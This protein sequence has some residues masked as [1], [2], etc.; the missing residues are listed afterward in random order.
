MILLQ[1][2]DQLDRH[3]I[4]F[5]AGGA[6][7]HP[8]PDRLIGRPALEDGR[9]HV[10]RQPDEGVRIAE[11]AR[12]V[13][14]Q[15][16]VEAARLAGVALE[17]LDVVADVADPVQR[18]P[19]E[20]PP[21]DG[22]Q[23]VVPEVDAA[24]RLEHVV[25]PLQVVGRHIVIVGEGRRRHVAAHAELR[26]L[27]A[28]RRRRQ[29]QIDHPG[30]DRGA[31]HA[32]VLRRLRRLR[33][34]EAAGALHV[35]QPD[36]A[37]AG[38]ARQDHG[39]APLLHRLGKGHEEGV[40]RRMAGPIRRP[41]REM[42]LG[43]AH[44]HLHVR[45]DHVDV[46]GLDP[47]AFLGLHHGQRGLDGEQRHQRALVVGR[48]VLDEDDG[49]VLRLAAGAQ[50][51]GERLEA[52]GRGADADD[53]ERA[54]HPS[55]R[56]HSGR[57]RS[58]TRCRGLGRPARAA[59]L[60]GAARRRGLLLLRLLRHG[61]R[62]G[63]HA[64]L[65]RSGLPADRRG[66]CDAIALAEGH[67]RMCSPAGGRCGSGVSRRGMALTPALPARGRTAR[68]RRRSRLEGATACTCVSRSAASGMLG[69][70]ASSGS[71]TMAIPPRRTIA[72]N[73]RAPSSSAPE[74][75]TP[76]TPGPRDRAAVRNRGSTAGRNR[77][78][79]GPR[80]TRSPL[81]PMSTCRSAGA[82]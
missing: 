37:V 36:G 71:W 48:E 44:R 52:A 30:V 24:D 3:R 10:R 50:D 79:R 51:L 56:D 4:G 47:H 23:L 59:G 69:T 78:S 33:E 39:D 80:T 22:R 40:D 57:L 60:H 65:P 34:R 8:D 62:G 5:L 35:G 27:G 58:A 32:V 76:M 1:E 7:R 15:I 2:L 20:Q 61:C 55:R 38:G 26:Q 66:S 63:R 21:L 18:H 16:L 46:P 29:H 49:D 81:L 12:H 6:P 72:L 25:D 14:Q 68:S 75:M 43:A 11:E 64:S 17:Q 41:R 28:D 74:R 73:P 77:F 54:A 31:R 45:R 53:R 42:Q 9:E 19:P 67:C 82:T 70:S 13:D